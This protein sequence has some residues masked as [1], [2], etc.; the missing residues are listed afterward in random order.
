MSNPVFLKSPNTDPAALRLVRSN[1]RDIRPETT[2]GRPL[3]ARALKLPS[4]GILKVNRKVRRLVENGFDICN[5]CIGQPD[6]KTPDH[7]KEKMKWPIDN[8]KNGYTASEGIVEA[9]E[10][11]AYYLSITRGINASPE[12]VCIF[13]GAKPTIGPAIYC[14]AAPGSEVIYP[15]PGFPSYGIQIGIQ[16]TKG[17]PIY[18]RPENNTKWTCRNSG[19]K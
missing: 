19:K 17:V 3:P 9:Q 15:V 13:H 2:W 4:E 18:L 7:V 8:D 12:N 5:F 1:A 6:F 14:A 16:R 11:V 10:A